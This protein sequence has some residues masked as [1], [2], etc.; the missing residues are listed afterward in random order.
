[1]NKTDMLSWG[2]L[3]LC[4]TLKGIYEETLFPARVC[5]LD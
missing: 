5:S 4:F 1:M 3:L 2:Y